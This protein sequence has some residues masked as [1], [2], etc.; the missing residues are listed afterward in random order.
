MRGPR[1]AQGAALD[2]EIAR[3]TLGAAGQFQESLVE[4]RVGGGIVRH[5]PHGGAGQLLQP[6]IG[7]GIEPQH[8]H[9]IL[10][11]RN[12]RQEQ[13]AIEATLVEVFRRHVR[14]R[15]HHGAECKQPL[16]Q[17][18]EDHRVRNVGDMEFI[19]AEQPGL[20]ENGLRRQPHR[21]GVGDLAARDLLPEAVDSFVHVG[22]EFMEVGAPFVADRAGVEEQIHQHGLA[23]ADLTMDIQAAQRLAVPAV[24]L[25]AEQPAEETVLVA[26]LVVGEPGVQRRIGLDRQRLRRIGLDLAG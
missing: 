20:V 2:R 10:D 5:Q 26:R 13:R 23:A 8:L 15:H 16:E 4:S 25:V 17:P 14:R 21:I 6:E 19:E 22:H 11:L 7:A 3:R 24:L 9:V 12:E 1:H 18:T